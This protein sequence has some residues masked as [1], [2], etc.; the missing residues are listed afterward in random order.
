[1][2]FCSLVLTG[3]KE[4]TFEFFPNL[5]DSSLECLEIC[6]SFACSCMQSLKIAN[7]SLF[8]TV[9]WQ[10]KKLK[11][12]RPS[13]KPLRCLLDKD[14]YWQVASDRTKSDN[15]DGLEKCR[16]GRTAKVKDSVVAL[17]CMII[18]PLTRLRNTA[19]YD[20]QSRQ[21]AQ[22]FDSAKS[23]DSIWDITMHTVESIKFGVDRLPTLLTKEPQ[24][25]TEVR[26]LRDDVVLQKVK[27]WSDGTPTPP[28][29]FF[30]HRG[31][32]CGK[33]HWQDELFVAQ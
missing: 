21:K 33:C 15:E 3:L 22:L 30:T 4:V 7:Y 12:W 20:G 16:K 23:V 5:T 18:I 13:S 8:K 31:H 29:N 2:C 14:H 17:A 11:M 26:H 24:A 9:A 19:L 1:M 32:K 25:C 27:L 6:W 28:Y 10:G